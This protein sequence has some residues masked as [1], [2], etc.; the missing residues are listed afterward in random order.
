MSSQCYDVPSQIYYPSL[1]LGDIMQYCGTSCLTSR[2]GCV[3]A[4][5]GPGSGKNSSCWAS[6]RWIAHQGLRRG[7]AVRLSLFGCLLCSRGV[8]R[9]RLITYP[10]T[11]FNLGICL[12]VHI[13][14]LKESFQMKARRAHLSVRERLKQ[15]KRVVYEVRVGGGL[16]YLVYLL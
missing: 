14:L 3:Y 12:L 6:L 5:R 8:S 4:D 10:I 15:K 1:V 2:R 7:G 13:N 11:Q 9:R 16:R